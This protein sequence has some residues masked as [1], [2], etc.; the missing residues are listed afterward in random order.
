M[1]TWGVGIFSDD[2]ACDIKDYYM[3]CLRQ[4]MDNNEAS[5]ATISSYF[6][7][8]L[9]AEDE[10][11]FWLSLALIQWKK[12]R[13]VDKVKYKAIEIIDS[14]QNLEYWKHTNNY[15]K[16]REV[17]SKLKE[18][19]NSEMP[20]PKPVK[21]IFP[22]YHS[23]WHVGT[24]LKY[25]LTDNRLNE[26]FAKYGFIGKY[27]LLQLVK[28]TEI[29]D[30]GSHIDSLYFALFDW[31][32]DTIPSD[33]EIKNLKYIPIETAGTDQLHFLNF[34]EERVFLANFSKKEIKEHDISEVVCDENFVNSLPEFFIG[35]DETSTYGPAYDLRIANAIALR[36]QVSDPCLLKM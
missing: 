14:N 9:S 1:G 35:F 16:R 23:L 21:K 25:K 8:E 27:V 28:V 19:L 17:L 24:V 11:V 30:H 2:L 33:D 6:Q 34:P 20:P 15:N 13:L 31:Y 3:D 7:N 5:N 36:G 22:D 29:E 18:T 12:G 10:S 32:G 26:E 4:K